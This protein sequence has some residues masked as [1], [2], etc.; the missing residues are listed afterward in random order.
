MGYRILPRA[1]ADLDDIALHT[2]LSWGADQMETYLRALHDR[3]LR[4]ADN[5][6]A[7]RKREEIAVGLLSYVQ[8]SHLIFYKA[9]PDGID[10]LAF[11]HQAQD[12][13]PQAGF[14]E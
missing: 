12:L 6:G 5:P 4:L 13:T 11:L 14:F 1:K 9:T 2:L 7:G 3:F 8:G 10:V